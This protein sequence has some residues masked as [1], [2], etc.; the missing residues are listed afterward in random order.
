MSEINLLPKERFGSSRS[1]ETVKVVRLISFVSFGTVFIFSLIVFF[2]QAKS[3]LP[4][5]KENEK[6]LTTQLTSM[7]TRLAKFM[8]LQD[9][10]N[11]ISSALSQRP[12][13]DSRI[14]AITKDIPSDITFSSVAIANDAISVGVS[15]PSLSSLDSFLN[16]L[17]DQA[18]TG[19]LFTKVTLNDFSYDSLAN[20]YTMLVGASLL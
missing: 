12:D 5:L 16:K 1:K 7:K 17:V 13:I 9:R 3:P 20:A 18:K 19:K 11:S 2:I 14:D 6:S 15:S 4:L 8:I 10:V